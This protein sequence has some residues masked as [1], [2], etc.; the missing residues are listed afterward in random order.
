M[1]NFIPFQTLQDLEFDIIKL[2]VH[3]HCIAATARLRA[4]DL[5]PS[6]DRNL[7]KEQLLKV[8][9]LKQIRKEGMVFPALDFE[10]ITEELELLKVKHN[11]L[12]AESFFRIKRLSELVNSIIQFH[13]NELDR[14]KNL[15]SELGEIF[16][17]TELLDAI[18]KVLDAKGQV[19]DDASP[20]LIHIRNQINSVKRKISSNFNKQLKS[21][22]QKG[23][24]ADSNETFLFGKRVLSVISSYKRSVHGNALGSSKTG[25]ITFIEPSANIP[26]NHELEMLRDDERSE[27]FRIL[28]ELTVFIRNHSF[29]LSEYQR[30]ITSLD[31]INAKCRLAIELNS[32]LPEIS[33]QTEVK[34]LKAYHPIL[35]KTNSA[36]GKHTI[37]QTL[38]LDKFNRILVISGPNAGGKSISLKTVGL[39]QLMLQSGLLIPVDPDSKIGI[40]QNILTDIG[41]NQSIENQL[42][43]YSYRLKRMKEFLEKS[44][45]KT[46]ILLDEFGTGSDP[47][48]GG[49]MA[50]VF[51]EELYNKKAFGVITTHY[52]NIKIKA[53]KLKNAINCSMLFNQETLEPTYIL[54]IGTPGSSF[55]FEVAEKNGIPKELI[56]RAKSRLDDNKI[57]M[58]NLLNSLQKEKSQLEKARKQAS[59][60]RQQAERTKETFL[61]KEEKLEQKLE[62]QRDSAVLNSEFIT[63]GKKLTQFI[64]KFDT[65][66]KNK[67]LLADVKK[68][69]AVEKTKIIQAQKAAKLKKKAQA[70]KDA[71]LNIVRH[72]ENQKKIDVGSRVRLIGAK[73]IGE[74]IKKDGSE[75]TVLFGNLK[76]TLQ[77]NKLRFIS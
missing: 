54:N 28:R 44:N 71:K 9:E 64:D 49:A 60:Q 65:R 72:T 43:T 68:Y 77:V 66:A 23:V 17:T 53:D 56:E 73:K 42:S 3:D 34:L 15:K 10:E 13:D 62:K 30:Y 58:D 33:D 59:S 18:N 50:E 37:P 24:L 25:N 8:N 45:K 7:I 57:K 61:I 74:V 11:A 51:F 20:E 27:I 40:F 32:N 26:L 67:E 63:K 46:L 1:Q 4:V 55:T 52:T 12:S 19:R 36:L 5:A 39:L 29:L 35:F 69:L 38:L 6:S 16:Q 48:L 31:F 75:V 70:K 76:T 21:L 14:F 47:D 22:S 2:M 41:D